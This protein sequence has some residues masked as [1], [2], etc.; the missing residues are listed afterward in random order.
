MEE[1]KDRCVSVT[2][3]LQSGGAKKLREYYSWESEIY[4]KRNF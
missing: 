2:V 3:N 4:E 1:G